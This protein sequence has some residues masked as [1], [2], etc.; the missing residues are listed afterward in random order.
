MTPERIAKLAQSCFQRSPVIVLGSGASVPHNIRGMGPLADFVMEQI[1]PAGDDEF[2]ACALLDANLKA[3]AG[4]EEALQLT[5]APPSLVEKIVRLAWQMITEDDLR[6]QDRAARGEETFPLSVLF[7]GL[8]RSANNTIHVV[9]PNYDRLVEY[10]TDVAGFVHFTG[11][12]PGLIRHREG[13]DEISI[14]RGKHPA[15]AVRIWKVHGSLDWFVDDQG[16]VKA[17]PLS[18]S[19][20]NGFTPL[21]VTPGVSKYQRTHDEP[22]RSA[23]RG[24]DEA[25]NTADAFLCV[26]YGFRDEHIQP[27]LVE[28]CRQRNVPVVVLAR[29]LTEEA[30]TFLAN[31]A[32][33][34]YLGIEEHDGGTRVYSP[35]IP[36]GMHFPGI[37]LWSFDAFNRMVL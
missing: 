12:T 33:P 21:I 11:F 18:S 7:A 6:V 27:K 28:R 36:D 22:F 15:R 16:V 24:A 19:V 10:A 4:L 37:D 13:A 23:I 17:L 9:T 1:Q 26:G 25:L 29:S 8:F 14:S 3:G 31:N 20:P 32:G 35:E 5:D 30:R 2:E 34:A